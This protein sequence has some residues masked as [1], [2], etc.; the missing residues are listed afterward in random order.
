MLF[1]QGENTGDKKGPVHM[2][3]AIAGFDSFLAHQL[4]FD[5]YPKNQNTID[6][7]LASALES[8]KRKLGQT[9]LQ[10]ALEQQ[11]RRRP[12]QQLVIPIQ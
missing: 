7:S 1:R 10:A 12:V 9:S 8:R 4:P 3:L 5:R 2:E 6:N 11:K